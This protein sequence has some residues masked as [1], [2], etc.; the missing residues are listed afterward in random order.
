[1]AKFLDLARHRVPGGLAVL[2]SSDRSAQ[3]F[4]EPPDRPAGGRRQT[5]GEIALGE[6]PYTK[7]H[8]PDAR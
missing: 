3:P 8:K 5:C 1:M 4:A 6:T 2:P 7:P